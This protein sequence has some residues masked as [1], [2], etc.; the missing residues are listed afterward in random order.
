MTHF[1]VFSICDNGK[2]FVT[3]A[4]HRRYPYFDVVVGLVWSDDPERCAGGSDAT[5]MASRA[6][7]VKGDDPDKKGYHV[8]PCLGLCIRLPTSPH[9]NIFV[10]KLLKC[11]T[12]WKQ[13]RRRS[14][15]KD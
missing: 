13:Q 10:R 1:F 11:E 8:P 6:R 5:G 14:T 7:Q 15:S 12:G 4:P 9:K 3:V 2:I